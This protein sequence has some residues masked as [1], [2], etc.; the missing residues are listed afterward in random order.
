MNM[1]L[2]GY[3]ILGD[4]D[5]PFITSDI[6]CHSLMACKVSAEKSVH[7]FMGIALYVTAWFLCLLSVFDFCHFNYNLS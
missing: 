4:K 6:A 5:F 2:A 7:N 3:S 1:S